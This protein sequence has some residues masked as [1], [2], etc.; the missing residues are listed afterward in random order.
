MST[1]I[2]LCKGTFPLWNAF[3]LELVAD[4]EFKSGKVYHL[5]G[6]NG[7]G[8]SSFIR[9]CLL[10]RIMEKRIGYLYLE[11]QMHTQ[12]SA[13]KA[14]AALANYPESIHSEA[15]AVDYLL[16]DLEK[17]HRKAEQACFV[18]WDE[19]EYYPQ[20]YAF[21]QAKNIEFVLLLVNH[22]QIVLP[23]PISI[24]RLELQTLSKTRLELS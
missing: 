21:L 22:N 18:I 16:Y 15:E 19:S 17:C 13:I 3:E 20:V 10:P 12:L 5:D 24:L 7:S 1:L 8:K 6:R 2:Q 4:L 14:N 11:Q 23:C 9:K